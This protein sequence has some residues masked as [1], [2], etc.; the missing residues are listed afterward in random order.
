MS[1]ESIHRIRLHGPWDARRCETAGGAAESWAPPLRVRMPASWIEL[2]GAEPG[3]GEFTRHF[4]WPTN[5][6]PEERVWLVLDGVGGTGIVRLN[7]EP[8]SPSLG[9]SR[10]AEYDITS[11]LRSSNVLLVHLEF[12]PGMESSPGGLYG[13]VALEV[14]SSRD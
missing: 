7:G 14:R 3:R 13:T 8:L 2:F 6:E 12:D 10:T 11:C 9:S 4:Q 1:G 5:L